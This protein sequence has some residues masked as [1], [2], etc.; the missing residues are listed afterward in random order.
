[1]GAGPDYCDKPG[2]YEN[3]DARIKATD[4]KACQ[5]FDTV[6]DKDGNIGLKT[7]IERAAPKRLF[8]T[9]FSVIAIPVIA[10]LIIGGMRLA[11]SASK[12]EVGAV[13]KKMIQQTNAIQTAVETNAVVFQEYL[14]RQVIVEEHQEKE[15]KRI[16]RK[17][18]KHLEEMRNGNTHSGDNPT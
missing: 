13:E 1:M 17:I 2:C 3:F 10:V 5:V 16:E 4:K 15:V 8:W 7:K 14:K 18:D 12:E 11:G 6:F 9:I